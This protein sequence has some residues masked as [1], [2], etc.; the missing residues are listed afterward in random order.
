MALGKVK[1]IKIVTDI[2]DDEKILLI[3]SLPGSDSIIVIWFKL[4]CLAGK[5]N[6]KGVFL[7]NDRIPYTDEMLA[8]IFRKDVK[9]VRMA[10]KTFEQFEMIEMVNNTITIPNW[11]KHQSLDAY[12]KKKERDRIYQAERRQ[13]QKMLANGKKSSDTSPDVEKNRALD[14]DIDKDIEIDRDNNNNISSLSLY[15]TLGFGTINPVTLSDI[16][17]LEKDYTEV[18][19]QE[20]LKEANSNGKRNLKYVKGILKN[21]KT[22][23]FKAERPN[24]GKKEPGTGFNNFKAREYDYDDLEKKL[25]GWEND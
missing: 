14:I 11:D 13:N 25:L 9:T 21:W 20:A 7:L 15:E 3:E 6:N 22:N 10:L 16:E 17:L 24:Y 8:T 4:L 18:W 23:G 2:F 1:W 12:E 5:N 19:V